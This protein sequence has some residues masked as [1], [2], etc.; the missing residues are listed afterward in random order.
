MDYENKVQWAARMTFA[1]LG[2]WAGYWMAAS[3]TRTEAVKQECAHYDPKTA[4]FKWGPLQ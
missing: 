4:E 2:I 1:L 3:Y